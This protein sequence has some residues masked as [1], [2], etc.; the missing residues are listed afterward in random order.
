MLNPGL[1]LGFEV[2]GY[3]GSIEETSCDLRAIWG[4][5]N[6]HTEVVLSKELLTLVGLKISYLDF[7]VGQT[8]DKLILAFIWPGHAGDR[9]SLGE[10]VTNGF[11]VLPL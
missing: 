1:A 3:D 5:G 11:L 8:D 10:L 7:T 6:G 9:G 2:H 4:A